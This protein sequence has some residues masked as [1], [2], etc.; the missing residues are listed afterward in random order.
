MFFCPNLPYVE[1]RLKFAT[2]FV[3]L[4]VAEDLTSEKVSKNFPKETPQPHRHQG[5]LPR[6]ILSALYPYTS[7]CLKSTL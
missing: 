4:S 7:P 2:C 6:K 5:G 3:T 1:L